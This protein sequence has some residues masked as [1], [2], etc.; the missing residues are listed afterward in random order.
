[1]EQQIILWGVVECEHGGAMGPE[2]VS[3][4]FEVDKHSEANDVTL[5]LK[6][7]YGSDSAKVYVTYQPWSRIFAY[8]SPESAWQDY[9]QDL[10]AKLESTR[11]AH[12]SAQRAIDKA[13]KGMPE[14]V[15]LPPS[16]PSS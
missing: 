2:V 7:F 3:A 8:I 16:S 14:G 9:V 1:M 4:A 15:S 13:N 11:Y 6:E 12:E 10:R 5:R